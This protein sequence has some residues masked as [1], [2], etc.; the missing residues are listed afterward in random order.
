MN[1]VHPV[2]PAI[3]SLEKYIQSSKNKYDACVDVVENDLK[4]EGIEATL[5]FHHLRFDPNGQPKFADLANCLAD[6]VIQ[7]CFSARRRGDPKT[8]DEYSRLNR[9]AR[10]LLR[11]WTTSGESGEMLLYLL[12]EVVLGA[13]QVVAKYDLKTNP[14]L[15]SHGS[16]GIHMKWHQGDGV[17]DIYFGEAKLEQTCSNALSN[18]FKSI[19]SFHADRLQ[20]HE[21]GLVTS[22]FKWLDDGLKSA[23][24]NY[25]DRQKP[26]GDCRINHACLVGYDWNEYTK[27][28]GLKLDALVKEFKKRYSADT[29]RLVKLLEKRFENFE[30][31]HLRFEVFFL[32]FRTVQEFR[33]AFNAAVS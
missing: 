33:D 29:S 11:K 32:P 19:S 6:H 27:L 4:I 18:A 9:E 15:E 10:S 28:S 2:P 25:V 26:G 16:D 12:I 31:K 7:Y 22:H 8:D 20:E 30:H 24:L 5:R 3:N 17:L 21:C 13:P 23:V 1:Q 14:K